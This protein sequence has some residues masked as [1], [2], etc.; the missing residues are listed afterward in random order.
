MISM[1]YADD[2]YSGLNGGKKL[3]A[4]VGRSGVLYQTA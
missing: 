4:V 3:R 1:H 2:R